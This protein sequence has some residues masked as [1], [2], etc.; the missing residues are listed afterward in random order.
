MESIFICV[1][2]FAGRIPKE[3]GALSKLGAL[4]LN[5]NQ[6]TGEVFSFQG[7][8]PVGIL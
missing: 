7:Y 3:L 4:R 2:P 5:G 8:L 1:A 6:L